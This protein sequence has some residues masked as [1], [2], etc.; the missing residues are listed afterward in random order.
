MNDEPSYANA[1]EPEESFGLASPERFRRQAGRQGLMIFE[2]G[3]NRL[4]I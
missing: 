4:P 3:F 2:V 1:S